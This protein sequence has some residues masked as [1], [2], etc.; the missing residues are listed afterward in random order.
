MKETYLENLLENARIGDLIQVYTKESAGFL[1]NLFEEKDFGSH[2]LFYT[3][4]PSNDVYLV[5]LGRV[6]TIYDYT[7]DYFQFLYGVKKLF[8][9]TNKLPG[10]KTII[11][12]EILQQ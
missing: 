7:N 3:K 2:Y 9:Y 5:Y 4:L 10:H 1:M 6:K 11:T 8:I 12:C